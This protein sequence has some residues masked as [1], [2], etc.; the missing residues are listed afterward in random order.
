MS[1]EPTFTERTWLSIVVEAD[2]DHYLTDEVV[3]EFSNDRK[4]ESTDDQDTGVYDGT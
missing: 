1:D 3:Y 4:F 2:P